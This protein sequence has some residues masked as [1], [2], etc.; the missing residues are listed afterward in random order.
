MENKSHCFNETHQTKQQKQ[1]K[2]VTKAV[3]IAH[4]CQKLEFCGDNLALG[5]D[6]LILKGTARVYIEK[7]EFFLSF[8]HHLG[9]EHLQ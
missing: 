9:G 3:I 4:H 6:I 5:R 8:L 2:E 7:T 1:R